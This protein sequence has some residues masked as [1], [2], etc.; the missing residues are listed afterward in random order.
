MID[1]TRN[2]DILITSRGTVW[3]P[4]TTTVARRDLFEIYHALGDFLTDL[5]WRIEQAH[6]ASVRKE[7]E[8][9]YEL[10]SRLRDDLNE[11]I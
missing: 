5:A 3:D 11:R 2:I 7:L 10:I 9:R 6:P 8:V 1:F 4:V